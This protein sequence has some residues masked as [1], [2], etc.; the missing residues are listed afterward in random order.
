[1][2]LCL[3]E[4]KKKALND[5]KMNSPAE[6]SRTTQ[7]LQVKNVRK[8]C[9]GYELFLVFEVQYLFVQKLV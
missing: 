3:I 2:F 6:F 5:R 9:I 8:Y 1:M 7:I 4:E